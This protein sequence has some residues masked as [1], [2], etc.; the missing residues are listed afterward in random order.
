MK[1]ALHPTEKR[2]IT[3][4]QYIQLFG[5]KLDPLGKRR[6]RPLARCPACNEAMHPRG[7]ADPEVDGV[8]AHKPKSTAYCPLKESAARPYQILPP[9]NPDLGKA[10]RLRSA[11]F[12]HWKHHW[13][14]I[15]DYAPFADIKEFI[16]LIRHA[17][18]QRLWQY[19]NIQELEVPFIFLVLKDFPPIKSK[20]KW[21][22]KEWIRFW[23]DSR[24]RSVEDLW[25]NTTGD[26]RIVKAIYAVPRK[27]DVVPGPAQ[28]KSTEVP[29]LK[30]NFLDKVEPAVH[31]YQESSMKAAFP[32]E[33]EA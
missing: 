23:F 8:F 17:D 30:L 27:K 24:V 13:K 1:K 21:L 22:R 25:I 2:P 16:A 14:L 4:V 15:R 10:E 32:E 20:G 18:Q 12:L 5:P 19:R 31:P 7:E 11:F 28:L 26:W 3:V 29:P 33:L 9:T 6:N